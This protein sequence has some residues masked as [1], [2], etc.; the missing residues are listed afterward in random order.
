MLCCVC[1]IIVFVHVIFIFCFSSR[2]RHTR[3]ALVTGFQTCALPISG[4]GSLRAFPWVTCLRMGGGTG[5]RIGAGG[6]EQRG[7]GGRARQ[8]LKILLR[9]TRHRIAGREAPQPEGEHR[10]R[11]QRDEEEEPARDRKSKRLKSSNQCA[12]RMLAAARKQKKRQK[13]ASRHKHQ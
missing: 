6:V 11:P 13:R 7:D 1:M 10:R 8:D 3:C 5:G 4:R 2:R 9:R 12:S